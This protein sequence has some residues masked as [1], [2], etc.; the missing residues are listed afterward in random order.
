MDIGYIITFLVCGMQGRSKMF[1]HIR[2]TQLGNYY[3]QHELLVKDVRNRV[4]GGAVE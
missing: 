3:L 2:F 1:D 4:P